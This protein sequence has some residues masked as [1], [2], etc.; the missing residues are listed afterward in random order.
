MPNIQS[1][2][3]YNKRIV[4]EEFIENNYLFFS[5]TS[6][7]FK[8]L[9][10]AFLDQKIASFRSYRRMCNVVVWRLIPLLLSN[11]GFYTTKIIGF[12]CFK[13][14]KVTTFKI[15][16]TKNK[17]NILIITKVLFLCIDY[18]SIRRKKAFFIRSFL[19]KILVSTWHLTGALGLWQNQVL[20]LIVSKSV[21]SF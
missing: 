20:I 12:V 17:N 1:F 19:Y 14:R 2:A 9:G 16:V 8:T 21:G 13:I 10:S 4:S 18:E 7:F 5:A 15:C 3:W 11:N 6:C